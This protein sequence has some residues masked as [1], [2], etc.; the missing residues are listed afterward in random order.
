MPDPAPPGR[1]WH[2]RLG[3]RAQL[4]AL[5]LPG[6]AALLAFDSWTDYHDA[7]RALTSAYDQALV[8]PV[9]A[10]DESVSVGADGALALVQRFD[11]LSMFEATEA[12]QKYLHVGAVPLDAAGQP[13]GP[14]RSLMG[15]ADLPTPPPGAR[16]A[17]LGE[18]RGGGIALYDAQYRGTAVRIAQASRLVRDG[19]GRSHALRVQAAEGTS[20]RERSRAAVLRRELLEDGRMLLVMVLLVWVGLAWTLRPLERLRDML[21]RRSP[22]QIEPLDALH[23]PHEVAPLVEAVNHHIADH[24]L[25]LQQQA[26]F[27]ADAS[28]QLRTPLAIMMTQAGYALREQDP[29]KT[30]ETLQAIMD[31]LSRSRRVSEQLLAMAHASR[32][33]DAAEAAPVVD[34]N[35]VAR[36]VVLQYLALAHEMNQ[37]LGF[38]DARGDDVEDSE[39]SDGSDVVPVIPVRAQAAELHEV[40][41]NLLHNAI[42]HTPAGGR[43]T[44]AVRVEDGTAVA[45]VRDSGPGL[46]PEQYE[47]VFR[48]FH[49]DSEQPPGPASRRGGAGLGLAIARA[50][51]R[52]NGGDITFAQGERRADGGTGLAALLRLPL[53]GA[54]AVV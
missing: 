45:E 2:R 29:R 19:A 51:A 13:A 34:L 50:Y 42:R 1:A 25:L 38:A 30:R 46:A 17:A 33:A 44:V 21:R 48:R 8:E 41:A 52:R 40:L 39:R 10:L 28:H 22:E 24:R 18:N 23:V 27:L 53:A 9:V 32:A 47:A 15:P 31:Q 49:R 11:V 14:E 26:Q 3:I 37:D 5:L 35:T 36:E 54:A 12:R 6:M 7:S 4:L 16:A 20:W 43:I